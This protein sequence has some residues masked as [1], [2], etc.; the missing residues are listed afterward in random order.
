MNGNKI[1]ISLDGTSTP[2]AG[3]KS[4][5][6]QTECEAIEVTS[7]LTGA[8]KQHIAGRKGWSFSTSWLVMPNSMSGT[9]LRDLLRI[10]QT[11]TVRIYER[12]SSNTLLL[13]GSALCTQA[14]VTATR[15][16]LATGA[17][18]FVGNGELAIPQ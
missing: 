8:W 4:N 9:K 10:G 12:G 14:K 3:T 1:F 18:S 17:F 13:T 7:P 2:L 16:N 6:I 11:Y 5:E 15:G